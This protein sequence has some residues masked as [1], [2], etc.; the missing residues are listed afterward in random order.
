MEMRY[1]YSKITGTLSAQCEE[2]DF[3]SVYWECEE[4]LAHEC[5]EDNEE[6]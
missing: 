4:D 5:C 2:C 1:G 3:I 6:N